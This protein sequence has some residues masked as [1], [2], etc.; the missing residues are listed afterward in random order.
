MRRD[1]WL[2]IDAAF[3]SFLT[4]WGVIAWVGILCNSFWWACGYGAVFLLFLVGAVFVLFDAK[5]RGPTR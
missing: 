1:I 5:R 4:V 2:W 3:V